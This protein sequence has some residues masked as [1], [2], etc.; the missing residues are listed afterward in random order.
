MHA[1]RYVLDKKDYERHKR[2]SSGTSRQKNTPHGE[3]SCVGAQKKGQERNLK[4]SIPHG[5][6]PFL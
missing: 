6:P 3:C 5:V 2:Q 4:E 1:P